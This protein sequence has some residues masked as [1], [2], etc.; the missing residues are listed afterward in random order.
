MQMSTTAPAKSSSDARDEVLAF[1]SPPD[2]DALRRVNKRRRAA[3]LALRTIFKASSV[4]ERTRLL[5]LFK[6]SAYNYFC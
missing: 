6:K 2:P 4:S 5:E 1:A 3:I